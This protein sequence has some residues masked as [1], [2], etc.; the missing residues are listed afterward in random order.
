V[1]NDEQGSAQTGLPPDE[2][3]AGFSG[4]AHDGQKKDDKVLDPKTAYTRHDVRKA[5]L[6]GN[7]TAGGAGVE[8][9]FGYQLPQNDLVC[10]DFRSREKSWQSGKH[11]LTFFREQKLPLLDM[12]SADELVGNAKSDNSRYCLAK[13]G[14]VYVVYLPSGGTHDLDLG[15]GAVKYRVEW[16]NPRAGGDLKAGSVREL[17]GPGK[18]SLG[19]PPADPTEDWAVLVRKVK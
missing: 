14:E 2:G 17:T 15:S 3:Y 8:Y 18:H 9:Y 11:A 16:F 19:T 5:T 12:T 4:V 10:D 1:C 6:W 13:P 7:L